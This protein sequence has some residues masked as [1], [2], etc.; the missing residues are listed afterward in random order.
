MSDEPQPPQP[1]EILIEPEQQA[2]VWANFAQ[3]SHTIHEFTLDFVRL[4]PTRPTGI[5]VARVSVSPLLI[6]E[7]IDA[8]QDN[9]SKF[10]DK[11]MPVDEINAGETD[12]PT[13]DEPE[14]PENNG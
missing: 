1:L 4:D 10:A 14:E 2:G 3:V 5:V 7:L 6:S 12:E 11:S 8:L 9:W 13:E